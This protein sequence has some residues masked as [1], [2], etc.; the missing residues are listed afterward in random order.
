MIGGDWALIFFTVLAQLG[1]GTYLFTESA[2][3]FLGRK[4][5]NEVLTAARDRSR[6]FILILMGLSGAISFLHLGKPLQFILS[7]SNLK[8]S[9]LSREILF[10]LLFIAWIVILI[11]LSRIKI[12]SV[13][14]ERI[15]SLIGLHL[16][17][18]LIFVMAKL[19]ML[20][21][22]PL[23]DRVST[24]RQFFLTTFIL[25]SLTAAVAFAWMQE[26]FPVTKSEQTRAPLPIRPLIQIAL[27]LSGFTIVISIL[28]WTGLNKSFSAANRSFIDQLIPLI[29]F[30]IM[31]I[32]LGG[33]LL[34]IS[35]KV[36]GRPN[37]P[38]KFSFG[39]LLISFL[40]IFFSEVVGRF[41]F[42]TL[43]KIGPL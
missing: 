37:K 39:L 36:K 3:I 38:A 21:A 25:G 7:L 13:I 41:L 19:Y 24:P 11:F 43:H 4:R 42:F 9:W 10:L 31:L 35:L 15:A 27:I 20:P 17:L 34:M 33:L 23:W 28:Y 18:F 8:N 2:G 29:I 26:R 22:V 16:G 14:V 12:G 32:F 30:R 40:V 5:D 1:V 6:I